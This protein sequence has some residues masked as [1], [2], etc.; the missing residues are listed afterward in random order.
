MGRT[1]NPDTAR[2]MDEAEEA[3][4]LAEKEWLEAELISSGTSAQS[5][6]TPLSPC[7]AVAQQ[8]APRVVLRSLEC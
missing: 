2:L 4:D 5:A 7:P 3:G 8:L 6:S 1:L